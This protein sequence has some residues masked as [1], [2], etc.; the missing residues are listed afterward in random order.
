[1]TESFNLWTK[2]TSTQW[3]HWHTRLPTHH[4]LFWP[5]H[6]WQPT[7]LWLNP[8]LPAD[9]SSVLAHCVQRDRQG[10]THS[11]VKWWWTFSCY[12]WGFVH[13]L[14]GWKLRLVKCVYWCVQFLGYSCRWTGQCPV[15][16]FDFRFYCSSS[17]STTYFSGYLLFSLQSNVFLYLFFHFYRF[18]TPYP[19]CLLSRS[20]PDD[21]QA[22]WNISLVST[23]IMNHIKSHAFNLV[24]SAL[25]KT[26][27]QGFPLSFS[28]WC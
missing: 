1:M 15:W 24:C 9:G 21:P 17:S 5:W 16:P 23:V 27:S 18:N 11:F 2:S 19:P 6:Q 12:F 28:V 8:S 22:E 13:V 10:C 14:V 25:H 20:F 26:H 3:Y 4:P 7:D